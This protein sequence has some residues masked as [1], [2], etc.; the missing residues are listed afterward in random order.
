MFESMAY[1]IYEF[2]FKALKAASF[3][4]YHGSM[5]R[6]A[7]GNTMR[8]VLCDR[9]EES[10]CETCPSNQICNYVK[11]FY[12]VGK[13][14]A[15]ECFDVL[16]LPNP[17]IINPVSLGK[18]EFKTGDRLCFQLVFWGEENMSLAHYYLYAVKEME[19]LGFGADR[20]A[21]RLTSV[22]DIVNGNEASMSDLM[23]PLHDHRHF[24]KIPEIKATNHLK[25]ELLTPLRIQVNGQF[26][27]QITFDLLIKNIL[28]RTAMM[29]R[30]YAIDQQNV[31]HKELIEKAGSIKSIAVDTR[32][33]KVERHSTY[34]H[35]NMSIGGV[36]GSLVFEG[37][38]E[39]F[40]PFLELAKLL[41]IGKACTTGG[42]WISYAFT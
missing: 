11:L 4:G 30:Y 8:K 21:F 12:G 29:E 23:N 9:P 15:A 6:G 16:K 22:K 27:S 2:E 39:I 26:T 10:V 19:V 3:G 17:Y 31:P 20:Y 18:S 42:G 1:A 7:L 37:D 14:D 5:I 33:V 38:F 35:Q 25:I 34:K 13:R 24:M 40:I 36:I 28:R 32:W 41:H